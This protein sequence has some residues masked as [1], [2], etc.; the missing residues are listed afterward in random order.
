MWVPEPPH[1]PGPQTFT[2]LAGP[3]P[4]CED[5][6]RAAASVA[7]PREPHRPRGGVSQG[8]RQGDTR[9]PPAVSSWLSLQGCAPPHTW[10][11][12]GE[13]VLAAGSG[14]G[15]GRAVTGSNS[16]T[17]RARGEGRPLSGPLGTKVGE[18]ARL[19]KPMASHSAPGD[20]P[21]LDQ[22]HPLYPRG[23]SPAQAP[24]VAPQ[25]PAGLLTPPFGRNFSI[26][27]SHEKELG[28]G[29]PGESGSKDFPGSPVGNTLPSSEGDASSIP[30][31]GAKIPHDS[32][33][34]KRERER[35]I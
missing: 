20:A 2:S 26:Q 31:W 1:Q 28:H 33:P 17:R 6:R 16:P 34:K 27:A 8:F 29:T 32:Q 21:K 13:Q 14:C 24:S 35:V 5:H 30:G 15:G 23:H 10:R 3:L 19:G 25:C 4:A 18:N 7:S 12:P 9:P 11:L 22:R